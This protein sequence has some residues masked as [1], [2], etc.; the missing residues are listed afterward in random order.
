MRFADKQPL[1]TWQLANSSYY[2]FYAN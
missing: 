2:G 1:N